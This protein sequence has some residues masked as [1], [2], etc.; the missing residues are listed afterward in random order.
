M[1]KIDWSLKKTIVK[2]NLD[3]SVHKGIQF[4]SWR[5]QVGSLFRASGAN[6]AEISWDDKYALLES[7]CEDATFHKIDALRLQLPSSDQKSIDKLLDKVATVAAE[8]QNI[9]IHRHKFHELKQKPQQDVGTFYSELVNE[10][11]FC[12]FDQDF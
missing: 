8:T 9:W 11:K 3:L 1:A 4:E 12:K 10:V 2:Q 5:R 7:T 6:Q